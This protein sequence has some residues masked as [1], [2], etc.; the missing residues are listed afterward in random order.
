MFNLL[1]GIL[2]LS[3]NSDDNNLL[4]QLNQKNIMNANKSKDGDQAKCCQFT[5]TSWFKKETIMT[6]QFTQVLKTGNLIFD[7]PVHVLLVSSYATKLEFGLMYTNSILISHY[8]QD[9]NDSKA[10]KAHVLIFK[11]F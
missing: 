2:Q 5:G 1:A 6:F 7:Y 9:V 11:M 4:K 8:S 10:Q 3:N